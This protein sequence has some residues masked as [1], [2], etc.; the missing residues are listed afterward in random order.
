MLG[1]PGSGKT[2]LVRV[3]I[4]GS[5][6]GQDIVHLRYVPSLHRLLI[7]LA[8]TL[9]E[10]GHRSLRTLGRP[11]R[12]WNAWLSQQTSLHLKGLLWT[13]LEREPRTIV[14]DGVD[15]ASF[16][17]YRFLQRLYFMRGM[18]LLATATD[19]A[20]L[21]ALDRLF[22]D[23]RAILHLLPLKQVDAEHLF[24]MAADHFC[25]RH[26]DLEDFRDKVLDSAGGN[27]GQI[28]EMCRMA[29]NPMYVTGRHVKFAPLR[30]DVLMRFPP[31]AAGPRLRE[32]RSAGPDGYHVTR[33]YPARQQGEHD[34]KQESCQRAS[35]GQPA[36][37]GGGEVVN[38]LPIKD[39]VGRS[40]SECSK[41]H[42][43]PDKEE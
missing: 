29:S 40:A 41:Q 28:I 37:S 39:D 43:K 22:W 19:A 4:A 10:T 36:S 18:A 9:L 38:V 13:S 14:V 16:P 21:G 35:K 32:S 11:G 6:R 34:E 5:A 15:R 30:I 2:E 26:L 24:N 12:D 1:S 17:V 8:G 27:P 23:P 7:D 31:T 33:D 3:A 42:A 20:S 25:L